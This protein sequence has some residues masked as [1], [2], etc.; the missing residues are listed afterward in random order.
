MENEP[1]RGGAEFGDAVAEMEEFRERRSDFSLEIRAIR[2]SVVSGTRRKA[3]LRGA[4][5]A[6]V[7]NL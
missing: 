5:Y 3:V 2:P 6:W 1:K 7:P 4:A